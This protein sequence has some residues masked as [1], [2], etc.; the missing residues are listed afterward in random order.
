MVVS[1]NYLAPN[2]AL[3]QIAILALSVLFQR[4]GTR[5]RLVGSTAA[6]LIAVLV[7][8]QRA[9]KF[10]KNYLIFICASYIGRKVYG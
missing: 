8:I 5:F 6:P 4:S 3:F 9:H 2:V 7:R 1:S 10:S